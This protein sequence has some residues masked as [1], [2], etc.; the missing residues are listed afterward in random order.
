MSCK[1]TPKVSP[2]YPEN[3]FKQEAL[4]ILNFLLNFTSNL[5]HHIEKPVGFHLDTYINQLA[6]IKCHVACHLVLVDISGEVHRGDL[7]LGAGPP[8]HLVTRVPVPVIHLRR[9]PAPVRPTN[10]RIACALSEE[11][12][13]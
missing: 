1:D 5:G 7:H 12:V 2:R 8:A 6:E 13:C 3:I 9:L 4:R 10:G 11:S